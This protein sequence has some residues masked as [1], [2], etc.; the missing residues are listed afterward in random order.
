MTDTGLVITIAYTVLVIIGVAVALIVFRSTRVGFRVRSV[1]RPAL[2]RRESF[3]AL[4]SI[5]FLVIVLG[6]TITQVPYWDDSDA[7][8][9]Q[10]VTIT[11]RQFAWTIDPPR[12][13]AGV[14]TRIEVRATDV[15]HAL[16]IYDAEDRLIK[17]VNV[18]PSTKQHFVMT[19]EQ[20]GTYR[21]L[22]LE[23]CGLD[24]HL[25]ANDLEVT[26]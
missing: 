6:G 26:R 17:Q 19:F 13:R 2:E 1:G 7:K 4:L 9:S 23:F 25:M 24:H 10:R 11:G 18:L 14:R 21:L 22:C 20:P 8:T 3:W 15:S 12:I 16:G 5:V